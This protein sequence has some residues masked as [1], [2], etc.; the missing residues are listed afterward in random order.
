MQVRVIGGGVVGLATALEL[1]RS[2]AEVTVHAATPAARPA[3]WAAAGL[4]MPIP[5]WALPAP[6]ETLAEGCAAAYSGWVAEL[7][8]ETGADLGW[9]RNGLVILRPDPE[10]IAAASLWARRTRRSIEQVDASRVAQLDAAVAAEDALWVA[11]CAQVRNPRLL[12][13]LRAALDARGVAVIEDAPVIRIAVE[14]EWLRGVVTAQGVCAAEIV[15]ICA[16][17]WSGTLGEGFPLPPVRPVRG[18]ML[19]YHLAEGAPRRNVL[20]AGRYLV[21]RGDGHVLCGSTVEEVG[22]DDATTPEAAELLRQS[23]AGLAPVLAGLA[24]VRQ[25][26]GLRAGSPDGL[27]FIGAHPELA[28][29]YFN[30]GQFRNGIL[31]APGSARLLADLVLGREPWLDPAPF[32]LAGRMGPTTSGD[33]Q[34]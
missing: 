33:A 10:Q 19:L 3:S 7:A 22:F 15:V 27:P 9:T 20:G 28:G 21:P 8:E 23:A 31:L 13:T 30:T 14:G 32:R 5:P 29:L 6:L 25:W 24:P 34:A 17:A 26:S 2:G 4:L 16:G 12:K 1:S 18:Q 11:D